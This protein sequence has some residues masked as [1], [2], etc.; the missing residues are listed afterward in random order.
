M[1]Q[2]NRQS[3][4][5]RGIQRAITTQRTHIIDQTGTQARRFAHD[6][7]RG[8]VDRDDHIQLATDAFNDRRY[9]LKLLKWRY[10]SRTWTR[11]LAPDVDQR[12]PG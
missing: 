6:R 12:C 11:G 8:R 9:A 4:G 10:R 1:H 5:C 7:R 2:A 3:G